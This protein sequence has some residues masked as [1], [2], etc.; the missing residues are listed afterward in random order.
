MGGRSKPKFTGYL[1]HVSSK[2]RVMLRVPPSRPAFD[3]GH[4]TAARVALVTAY[5]TVL[6]WHSHPGFE[7]SGAHRPE[8]RQVGGQLVVR[9]H[10]R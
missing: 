8:T 1:Q 9:E 4:P 10:H 7:A 2:T 5:S 3:E 6:H